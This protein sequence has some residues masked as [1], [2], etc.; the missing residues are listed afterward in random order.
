MKALRFGLPVVAGLGA[1]LLASAGAAHAADPVTPP[2]VAVAEGAP[3]AAQLAAARPVVEKLFPAGTYRRIM[4]QSMGKMM[5]GMLDGMMAMPVKDLARIG[6]LSEEKVRGL[7]PATMQQ[8]MAILDPNFRERTTRGMQVMMAGI[9][10]LMDSFEPT[11]R[12]AL[13]RA[14]A[15]HFTAAQL[16]EMDR[17]FSTPTGT[18]FAAQ[19]MAMSGD[20]EVIG[21][22]RALMPE[23]MKKMPEMASRVQ[24]ASQALPPP[25]RLR[26][27]SKDEREKLARLLGVSPK[28][29]TDRSGGA[30]NQEGN[31]L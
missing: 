1:A 10:D 25:R 28:D 29:L 5:G 23:M 9:A 16:A 6:G 26:D 20:P 13:T 2:P 3:S 31:G 30:D 8:A 22:M 15:R 11:V 19:S 18:A 17:F 27:L 4:G 24:Q 12:D 21:A 7:G 14:Y